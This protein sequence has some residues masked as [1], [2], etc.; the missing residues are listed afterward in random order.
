VLTD[1]PL[2]ASNKDGWIILQQ[3]FS[4]RF[5]SVGDILR[6][7]AAANIINRTKSGNPGYIFGR[8]LLAGNLVS[9]TVENGV[10]SARQDGLQLLGA[11][12]DGTCTSSAIEK[13]KT[14]SP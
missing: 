1:V 9:A 13:A 5:Q 10:V 14:E 4:V 2:A 11:D 6:S 3:E 12:T 8:P 7:K